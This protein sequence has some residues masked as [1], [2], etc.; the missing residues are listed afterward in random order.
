MKIAF[1]SDIHEDIESL[2]KAARIIEKLKCDEVIC[3]GDIVG[4]SVPFYNYL[5]KRNANACLDW[6]KT[7]CKYVVKGNHDLFA[8]KEI[9]KSK[10]SDFIFSENWY[11]L[12]YTERKKIATNKI[13][14]YEDNELSA[15][16]NSENIEYLHSIP[17]SIII[18]IAKQK[19]MLS[20]YLYPDF[21]G[22]TTHFIETYTDVKQHLDYLD[23]QEILLSFT[24]H[25]H[26]EGFIYNTLDEL[27]YIKIEK[28]KHISNHTKWICVPPIT[29]AAKNNSLLIWDTNE[30]SI[31][32]VSIKKWWQMVF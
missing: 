17:E 3:L 4:Y 27:K 14:L 18:E 22:S 28:S 5:N 32:T 10:T 7:H 13:W 30:K 16:L 26:F 24:G 11:Q 9:P 19:I 2:I 29:Q 12:P 6:V 15:L 21:S 31:G 23:I 25:R 1:I 8:C 20:H